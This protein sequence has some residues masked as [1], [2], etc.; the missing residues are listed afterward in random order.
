MDGN[1]IPNAIADILSRF[2]SVDQIDPGAFFERHRE[3]LKDVYWLPTYMFAVGERMWGVS[4]FRS[5]RVLPFVLDQ[6][7]LARDRLGQLQPV[8]FVPDPNE[9]EVLLEECKARRIQIISQIGPRF[10]FLSLRSIEVHGAPE[11]VLCRIPVRLVQRVRE[12]ENLAA[13]FKQVIRAFAARHS[14]L[15]NVGN[16][17]EEEEEKLLKDTFLKFVAANPRF[18]G[19]Y[20]PLDMLA[21][22]EKQFRT[23]ASSFR[24]HFFH[25]FQSFLWGCIVVND[26]RPMFMRFAEECFL[27]TV[28][29]SP[30]YVWL[31]TALYHDIGYPVQ[32]RPNMDELQFGV[33]PATDLFGPSREEM[34]READMMRL[35]NAWESMKYIQARTQLASLYDHLRL[36]V[37]EDGWTAEPHLGAGLSDSLF[38]EA[39]WEAFAEGH[40]VASAI[41]ATIHLF[42][43][44]L[45]G[46]VT[47][48]GFLTR[49]AVLSGLSMLF[50]DWTVREALRRKGIAQVRASRFPF[51]VLL[52]YIDSIQEDRRAPQIGRSSIDVLTDL[53][54]SNGTVYVE[55]DCSRLDEEQLYNKRNEVAD[56]LDFIERDVL[57][58]KFPDELC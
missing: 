21:L 7:E 25:A 5:D 38:D 56:M 44:A 41:K 48:R 14:E 50:H 53:R 17:N 6:M 43:E 39:L 2:G 29:F 35:Q 51:A 23:L 22:F 30:E 31:L 47:R 54:I 4:I 16:L 8:Y 45:N 24:D 36:D 34:I 11:A 49:H 12:C 37:I 9:V 42:E 13:E 57:D 10:D 3:R 19:T 28:N 20:R 52:M 40:A 18:A 26:L 55:M 58:I 15:L 33:D 1:S 46:N 32:R 27:G